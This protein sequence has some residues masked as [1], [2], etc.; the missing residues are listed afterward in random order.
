MDT[1]ADGPDGPVAQLEHRTAELLGKEAALFFPTGTMAQQVALRVHSERRGRKSFAAHPQTHLVVWE[2]QGYNVVHELRFHPVGDRN[3]LIRT[4]DLA[5]VREPLAALVLELPQRDIGG[6]LP[7]WEDLQEQT[8]WARQRGAAVHLD[9]ARLWEAQTFYERPFAEIAGLFD[10]VYVSLYKALEGVRGAVLA[11]DTGTVAEAAVW[12]QR[13]GGSIPDAWPLAAAAM[14]G[15]DEVLP[16]MGVFRDHAVAL[17][18]AINA[19]GAAHT[20]PGRPQTPLFHVHLPAA[21]DDVERAGAQL[22]AER[23]IQI[24]GRVRSSPDSRRCSFEVTV[25]EN[26]M[27]FTPDEIVE[28]VRDLLKRASASPI[29]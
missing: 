13:L 21:K 17:A 29:D 14:L 7:I 16:R 22:V 24:F 20:V 9:G 15:L 2:E 6:Q 18:A 19:D 3:S 26:A 5:G 4:E 1:P 25:G 10:S 23:G 28:L 11:A 12:R 27:E 8:E